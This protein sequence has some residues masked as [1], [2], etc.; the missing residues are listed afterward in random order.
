MVR[1]PTNKLLVGPAKIAAEVGSGTRIGVNTVMNHLDFIG[2]NVVLLNN[3]LLGVLTDSN[4][5]V[6]LRC[7]CHSTSAMASLAAA[8]SVELGTV[9]VK[10]QRLTNFLPSFRPAETLIQSWAWSNGVVC[11]Y[12]WPH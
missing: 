2:R 1:R 12:S 11:W 4:D 5:L 9:N 8:S 7:P 6:G 10:Y 3:Q